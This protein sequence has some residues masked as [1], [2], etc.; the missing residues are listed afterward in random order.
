VKY[1]HLDENSITVKTWTAKWN[2]KEFPDIIISNTME[3]CENPSDDTVKITN[4]N[5]TISGMDDDLVPSEVQPLLSK[6]QESCEPALFFKHF[7]TYMRLNSFRRESLKKE[8]F[9]GQISRKTGAFR[10]LVQSGKAEPLACIEWIIKFDSLACSFVE[11]YSV[12]FTD[13]GKK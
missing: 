5:L 8:G 12:P 6:C 2:H 9:A 4:L 1:L 11:N 7:E 13:K 3:C 10:V